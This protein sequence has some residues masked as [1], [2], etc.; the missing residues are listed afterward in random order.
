MEKTQSAKSTDKKKRKKTVDLYGPPNGRMCV[1]PG[2]PGNFD[3]TFKETETMPPDEMWQD[4]DEDCGGDEKDYDEQ[5]EDD[6]KTL[7]PSPVE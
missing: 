5:C 2:K 6:D 4:E 7:P 1:I 3:L